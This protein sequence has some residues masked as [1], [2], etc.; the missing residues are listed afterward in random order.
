MKK[1]QKLIVFL[2]KKKNNATLFH[3][4]TLFDTDINRNQSQSTREAVH[5]KTSE[6]SPPTSDE[7]ES[8]TLNHDLVSTLLEED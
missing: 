4:L 2:N 7:I 6:E 8:S 1:N 3:D 5:T